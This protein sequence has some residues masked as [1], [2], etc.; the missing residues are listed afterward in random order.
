MFKLVYMTNE[1]YELLLSKRNAELNQ[2][3][4]ELKKLEAYA[5][6]A[7]DSFTQAQK[8]AESQSQELKTLQASEKISRET[9]DISHQI[10]TNFLRKLKSV[11]EESLKNYYMKLG[12]AELIKKEMT[13]I[14]NTQALKQEA[15]NEQNLNE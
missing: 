6:C 2:Y 11:E 4:E 15:Q 10:I 13:D 1:D 14:V 3:I 7:K 8:F 12:A 9:L 5:V